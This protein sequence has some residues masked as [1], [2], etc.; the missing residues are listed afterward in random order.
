[1]LENTWWPLDGQR[2]V[3][4]NPRPTKAKPNVLKTKRDK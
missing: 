1:M 4:F 2:N 3:K